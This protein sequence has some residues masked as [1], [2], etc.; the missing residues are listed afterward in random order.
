M[1]DFD[2]I[3][4]AGPVLVLAPHADDESL[5]CG[6]L[7][8]ACWRAGIA[9]HVVC[10]TDGAASHPGSTDWPPAR[11]ADLRR[12]ELAEA[13]VRLGGTPARDLTFLGHPDAALHLVDGA[14][15]A[16]QIDA[17]IERLG[18]RVLL[19]P[20]RHDAHCDHVAAARAAEAVRRRRPDLRLL[21]YPV[22]SR[23]AAGGAE[24][25]L[26]PGTRRL[27]FEA[28][29]LRRSKARAIAAHASQRGGVVHDDPEGFAMPEGFAA[30][31]ADAPEIFDAWEGSADA[32]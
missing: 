7:L 17:T 29:D 6:A 11:L 14:T 28:L 21:S 31:F 5:G 10:L 20:S 13:V 25:P 1:D 19:V 22:W 9:A 2:A 4:G 18:T 12:A 15:L 8:A 24:P 23:W 16:A 32:G 3:A 26:S 27:R 30:F